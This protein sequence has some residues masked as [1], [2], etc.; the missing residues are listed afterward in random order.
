[1][2]T[3]KLGRAW[4]QCMGGAWVVLPGWWGCWIGEVGPDHWGLVV[5]ISSIIL[6]KIILG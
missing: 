6:S 2:V 4:L 3:G 1:M 5:F